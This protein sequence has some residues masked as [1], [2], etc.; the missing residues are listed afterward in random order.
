VIFVENSNDF[1]TKIPDSNSFTF[2][3]TDTDDLYELNYISLKDETDKIS[4]LKA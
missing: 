1:S 4:Y 2:L 3:D